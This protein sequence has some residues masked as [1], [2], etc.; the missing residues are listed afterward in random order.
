[1]DEN[2]SKKIDDLDKNNRKDFDSLKTVISDLKKSNKSS[3]SGLKDSFQSITKT[4]SSPIKSVGD[5]FS[6]IGNDLISP[7]SSIASG[8][9]KLGDNI[10][11]KIGSFLKPK[12]TEFSSEQFK[13]LNQNYTDLKDYL[14]ILN[15]SVIN[16][17]D[18]LSQ[19]LESLTGN[20]L[21][22]KEDRSE[23]LKTLKNK[24]NASASAGVGFGGSGDSKDGG[25]SGGFLSVAAGNVAGTLIPTEKI[26]EGFKN[27]GKNIGKNI[28]KLFS[29]KN[30]KLLLSGFVSMITQVSAGLVSILKGGAGA[31]KI[32]GGLKAFFASPSNPLGIAITVIVGLFSFISGF[33]KQW[34]KGKGEG[35]IKRLGKSIIS[36]LGAAIKNLIFVPLDIL[37][38][39]VGFILGIF[40]LD[41]AK[42]ALASFS[43]ADIFQKFIDGFI[44]MFGFLSDLLNPIFIILDTAINMIMA[45]IKGIIKMIDGFISIIIESF[46]L[47]VGI[48]TL[49][50]EMIFGALKG[51][52]NGIKKMLS[53]IFQM[54]YGAFIELFK[55]LWVFFNDKVIKF[56]LKAITFIPRM[57][58]KSIFGALKMIFN[59]HKMVA[60]FIL[61]AIMFPFEMIKNLFSKNE[62]STEGGF[63]SKIGKFIF[64]LVT[65]PYR[66]IFNM[67]GKVF[68][69]LKGIFE[70]F[71]LKEILTKIA[72]TL[73]KIV[74]F[75]QMMIFNF[76]KS[77]FNFLTT[78]F[79][80]VG[81]IASIIADAVMSVPKK[82]IN[83]IL[84]IIDAIP[85][86]NPKKIP[87]LKKLAAWSGYKSEGSEEKEEGGKGSK[88]SG[89]SEKDKEKEE[90]KE[91]KQKEKEEKKKQK[92]EEKERKRREKEEAKA[93]AKA[94][95]EEFL[96]KLFGIK[97]KNK[98]EEKQDK[99]EEDEKKDDFYE[100]QVLGKTEDG[101]EIVG[102]YYNDEVEELRVKAAEDLER[103][104]KAD[105]NLKKFQSES[106]EMTV[107]GQDELGDDMMG[108]E[109]SEKQLQYEQL[110]SEL[111][112]AVNEA[113]KSRDIF[114]AAKLGKRTDEKLQ[115][116]SKMLR[117]M[118]FGKS[119]GLP[120]VQKDES[121]R[122]TN[123]KEVDNAFENMVDFEISKGTDTKLEDSIELPSQIENNDDIKSEIL[124]PEQKRMNREEIFSRY[125]EMLDERREKRKETI[126]K[127]GGF[128]LNPFGFGKK[129]DEETPVEELDE[130]KETIQ[131]SVSD[132]D[133]YVAELYREEAQEFKKALDLRQSELDEFQSKAGEMTVIGQ[134]ELGDDMMGYSDPE[135]QKEF[136]RLQSER[137]SASV[138]FKKAKRKY[139]DVKLGVDVDVAGASKNPARVEKIR[140]DA[141]IEKAEELGLSGSNESL[142][143]LYEK[144]IEEDLQYSQIP[145]STS[146]V[147]SETETTVPKEKKGLLSIAANMGKRIIDPFGLFSKKKDNEKEEIEPSE[148]EKVLS[149]ES[150]ESSNPWSRTY[151]NLIEEIQQRKQLGEPVGEFREDPS[152]FSRVQKI[153]EQ[154]KEAGVGKN[155][156]MM[157]APVI[158]ALEWLDEQKKIQSAPGGFKQYTA[159]EIFGKEKISNVIGMDVSDIGPK[160]SNSG[161]VLQQ[162]QSEIQNQ[163]MNQQSSANNKQETKISNLSQRTSNFQNV[164]Y[165]N[166]NLPDRT[167]ESLQPKY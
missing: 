160:T 80:S 161:Q 127:I 159:S 99:K 74:T 61:K 130:K 87:G 18:L 144:Q 105:S 95:K 11:S 138:D 124:K 21:Q 104:Q 36:G 60:K 148:T 33:F 157:K 129:D 165:V 72:S 16:T 30:F 128:L 94:K 41:M 107:I 37:K 123:V 44:K 146:K 113:E 84:G 67:I 154:M 149:N 27:L 115:L 131:D 163:K 59:F 151:K 26:T 78:K 120:E 1:M 70:S 141:L 91:R 69:F 116:T 51:I 68:D 23:L 32:I 7:F 147:K 114:A 19:L 88:D 122:I 125:Q 24:S 133:D 35:L 81:K 166:N 42:K 6:K 117:I 46:K 79:K 13:T 158:A 76:I 112:S 85:F 92:E 58:G 14:N 118:N 155:E 50:K 4:I 2:L 66:F 38:S 121:G 139:A 153:S 152:S 97:K 20:K 86:V 17:N 137:A 5:N 103:A 111:N 62:S 12:K 142:E 145:E 45:P 132:D 102:D 108:Y 25:G 54:I 89:S 43:F 39:V 90:E 101:K 10:G 75:P 55:G 8:F 167:T 52:W 110:N 96:R 83:F 22:E 40:G 63:I 29:G 31:G 164:S 136:E 65:F 135:K 64:K 162:N 143:N 71:N 28:K 156:I 93:E 119:L 15:V 48:F 140:R 126:K 57:I 49:D 56:I 47:L 109:D 3:T 106:G 98:E 82:I 9:S 77:I 134:N 150:S 34:R 53:G 73:F 100:R